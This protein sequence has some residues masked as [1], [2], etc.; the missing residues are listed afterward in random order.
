MPPKAD[1]EIRELHIYDAGGQ[2]ELATVSNIESVDV[3]VYTEEKY[4]CLT[5]V[6]DKRL[7]YKKMEFTMKD[8]VNI[9]QILGVDM[10]KAP[11]MYGLSFTTNLPSRRHKKKRINKKW[12]KR[13]GYK[14]TT[15]ISCGWRVRQ[16]ID[17]SFEFVKGETV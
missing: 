14:L 2:T 3:D 9:L 5:G 11:D 6:T 8:N 1:F 12:L 17:G 10:S 16:N 15:G 4:N 13:Y 7:R